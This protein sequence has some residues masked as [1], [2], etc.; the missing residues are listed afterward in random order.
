M[1]RTP[2][3]PSALLVTV[4][5]LPDIRFVENSL[6]AVVLKVLRPVVVPIHV[7]SVGEK[8]PPYS[9]QLSDCVS[10]SRTKLRTSAADVPTTCSYIRCPMAHIA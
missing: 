1:H 6:A 7:V 8:Y 4:P 5:A 3:Y 10:K 2:S 9:A